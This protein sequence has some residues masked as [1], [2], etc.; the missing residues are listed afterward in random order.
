MRPIMLTPDDMSLIVESIDHAIYQCFQW[1][2]S[3]YS[4]IQYTPE[5][6]SDKILILSEL[7]E[8][9]LSHLDIVIEDYQVRE[10]LPSNVVLFHNNKEEE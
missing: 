7:N 6:I 8:K 3:G 10:S 1:I 9:I 4:P 2:N 5:E